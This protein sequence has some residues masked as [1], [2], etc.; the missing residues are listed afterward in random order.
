MWVFRSRELRKKKK[1]WLKRP[2]SPKEEISNN[3]F[4]KKK[5]ISQCFQDETEQIEQKKKKIVFLLVLFLFS[6]F[7]RGHHL[8][9][10][11]QIEKHKHF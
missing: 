3:P 2:V 5:K 4:L 9:D 10:T 8:S 7:S 1:I 11:K 6:H